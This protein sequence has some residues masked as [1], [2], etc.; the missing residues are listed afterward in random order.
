FLL[1]ASA[2]IIIGKRRSCEALS[3][4]AKPEQE[5]FEQ[6]LL[7]I[8][9]RGLAKMPQEYFEASLSTLKFL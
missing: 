5:L 6:N 7:N 2:A 8:S 4:E 1:F 3:C 9:K